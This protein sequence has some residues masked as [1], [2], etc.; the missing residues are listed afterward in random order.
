ME[1]ACHSY[2]F[3]YSSLHL[4]ENVCEML[5]HMHNGGGQLV[6]LAHLQRRWSSYGREEFEFLSPSR[7][8]CEMGFDAFEKNK[9]HI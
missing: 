3:S 9:T 5:T 4:D 7:R 8:D 2:L 1:G 6:V